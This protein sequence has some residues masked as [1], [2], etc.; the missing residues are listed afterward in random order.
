[1]IGLSPSAP[2]PFPDSMPAIIHRG[3]GLLLCAWTAVAASATTVVPPEFPELV[4]GSDYIVRA[5]VKTVVP[6]ERSGPN[7]SRLIFSRVELEVTEVVAGKPPSPIVLKVLGGR[8]GD[9]EMVI[10][11]V[12]EFIAGEE[13]VFFI[14]GNGLQA[15]PLVRMMYGKYRIEK[16]ATSAREYMVR[17]NGELLKEVSEVSEHIHHPRRPDPSPPQSAVRAM[18]PEEFIQKIRAAATKPELREY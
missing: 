6:E 12:P 11:G 14:Q 5:V 3:I 9:R 13:G 8:I 10:T 4:N 17:S 16:E 18:S 15:Y 7:G 2:C 1:M